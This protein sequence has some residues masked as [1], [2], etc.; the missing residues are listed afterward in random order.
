MNGKEEIKE[1]AKLT[2]DCADILDEM[3]EVE[4]EEKVDELLV[5]YAAKTLRIRRL[6]E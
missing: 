5:R 2:R 1:A 3:A 4:E 6:F